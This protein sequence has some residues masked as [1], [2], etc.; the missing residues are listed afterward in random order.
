[1]AA[2]TPSWN[3]LL[4][5]IEIDYLGGVIGELVRLR[6]VKQDAGRE[7]GLHCSTI[8]NDI[9]ET[10]YPRTANPDIQRALNEYQEV[11]NVIEDLIA[12]RLKVRLAGWTKPEPRRHRM[13][14]ASPDGWDEKTRTIDEVKA[15]WV[16]ENQ[17]LDSPKCHGYL[18]Q[19]L[20]YAD[21]W[22]A[23]RVRLHVLFINGDWRPPRPRSRTFV[24]RW[25]E[26]ALTNNTNMLVRHAKD[27][28]WL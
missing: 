2:I 25:Q 1:M 24:F 11:G 21:A 4:S 6:K 16:S 12:D 22:E 13:I 20:F 8:V 26:D 5:A 23:R 15:T 19:T 14:W 27:R 18:M 10:V 7:R 3:P 17:F 9:I 28:G